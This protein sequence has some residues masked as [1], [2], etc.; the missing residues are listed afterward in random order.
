[1]PLTQEQIEHISGELIEAERTSKSIVALTERFSDVSYEDAYAIQLKTF[2]T[3]VKAGAV[4][5]GKKIGLTSKAMQDQFKIREPDYGMITNRMVIREG[6]PIPVSSLIL[7]RLEPEIA[8][9]L[10][11]DLKGPGIN[12]ANV[13]EATEGVLP[14]FEVI[15]SRYKDWKITVKDSISD[16]ASAA[17]MILGGKLTPI[18][19]IDL[20]LIGLVMEKNRAVV[21]TAAGAAV[22][23]NPA[24]SVAWLANKLTEY[25]ITL[26]KGEFV[27]SGSLVSAV[28]VEA[29]ASLRATFD[30]LG[31]VSVRFE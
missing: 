31:S 29:G 14:A 7:P 16:N 9:L 28:P 22:L 17:S 19:D 4:I 12:V 10:K 23:G 18:K 25:G 6:Q 21:S 27:M 8:F 20:R 24:E 5:V 30:R 2:D 15:D 3:R 1:M 26:K 11:E 13:I